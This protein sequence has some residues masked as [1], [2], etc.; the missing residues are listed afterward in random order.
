MEKYPVI[1][2][3][4]NVYK[5]EVFFGKSLSYAGI[6]IILYQIKKGMFGR[7]SFHEV[8]K[9]RKLI[10]EKEFIEIFGDYIGIVTWYI[11]KYEERLEVEKE[12]KE[13]LPNKFEEWDGFI[14]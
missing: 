12:A 13:I 3:N 8:A 9:Y 4:G 6:N 7:E 14:R 2:K 5:V 11:E 1:S 10:N